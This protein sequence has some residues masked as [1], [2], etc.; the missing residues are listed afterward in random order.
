MPFILNSWL[1]SNRWTDARAE[2]YTEMSPAIKAI[3]R[4]NRVMVATITEEP[5]CFVGWI[6]GKSGELHYVYIKSAFRRDGVAKELIKRVCGDKGVYTFR[7]RNKAFLRYLE[8]KGFSNGEQRQRD[9][10]SLRKKPSTETERGNR[11]GHNATIR[12]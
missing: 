7:T 5:D 11:D 2:Y 10:S 12:A 1:K 4:E 9:K 6:C 3:I 8:K